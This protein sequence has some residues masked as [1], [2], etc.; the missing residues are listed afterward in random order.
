MIGACHAVAGIDVFDARQWVRIV[1]VVSGVAH[2]DGVAF[3]VW[4]T[5]TVFGACH[6]VAGVC[7]VVL[8]AGDGVV[9]GSVVTRVTLTSRGTVNSDEAYT[10]SAAVDLSAGV[11]LVVLH[12]G[13]GVVFGSVVT[14]V[15]LTSRGIVNS[16]EAYAVSA[17]VDLSAGVGLVG[18]TGGVI[19]GI[20]VV[21]GI[22]QADN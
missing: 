1:R 22:T 10:V 3:G 11:C 15:T 2:T 13:D 4:A 16:D 18:D 20:E 8:H 7:L 14:K 9:F 17:A 21:A 19:E 5:G 12:A 6:A